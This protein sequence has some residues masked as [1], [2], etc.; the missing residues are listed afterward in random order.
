MTRCAAVCRTSR[1]Q[2]RRPSLEFLRSRFFH[3]RVE[4][5]AG[6]TQGHVAAKVG[7]DHKFDREAAVLLRSQMLGTQA[8]AQKQSVRVV[9]SAQG[10]SRG[11]EG[12]EESS[13]C[14]SGQRW[15]VR[16]ATGHFKYHEAAARGNALVKASSSLGAPAPRVE[17]GEPSTL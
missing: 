16:Q 15:V 10:M 1:K 7:I 17:P 9:D 4:R 6:K 11:G 14:R 2:N 12:F 13:A 3:H 5:K 8:R